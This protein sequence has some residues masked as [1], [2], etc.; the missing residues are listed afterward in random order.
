[1][2]RTM[3]AVVSLVIA[4]TTLHAQ[5]IAGTWQGTLPITATGQGSAPGGGDPR[6][7]FIVEKNSDGSFHGGMKFIDRSTSLPLTSIT[8]SA[9]DIT[10]AQSSITLNYH[11]K[12]SA[13]GKSIAGTWTQGNQTLPFNLQLATA[14]TLWKPEG[15]AALPPM[16]AKADPSFEVALIKP[17]G[18]DEN[19]TIFDLRARKFSSQ[20]TSAKELIKI[21]YN[22]R[23]RQV[24]GGPSWLE[25]R[26]Y[27]IVGEPDTPGLPSEAQNRAMVRKLLNERFHLVSHTDKQDFPV[28][29]LT[30]DPKVPRP[31]PSD[32]NFNGNGGMF[33]RK[34]GDDIVLQFSGST[35]QQVIGFIMNTFQDKQLVDETGLIGVYDITLRLTGLAQ[36]PHSS[37]EVGNTL[38]AAAQHAGFKLV[39]KKEPLTVVIIESI[40][41][42]TPN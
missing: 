29:A 41:S 5:S 11:G 13:D 8:L 12:L 4:A 1:M 26:K 23:G 31:T 16:A 28:L 3:L 19:N 25:E 24:L 6:I 9:Q 15:L 36:G 35:I 18:P 14:D 7:I 10:F 33:A 17:T 27:D 22:L 40:D 20:H 42:P 32:P 21:A 2:N 37:E 30:L 38:V 34:D 39:P